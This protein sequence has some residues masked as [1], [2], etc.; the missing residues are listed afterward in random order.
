MKKTSQINIMVEPQV[1]QK[2]LEKSKSL[3]LTLTG[4]VEKIALEPVC[5]LD[6]NVKQVLSALKLNSKA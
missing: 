3:N 2:L 6:E 5:F 4:Y 1:K